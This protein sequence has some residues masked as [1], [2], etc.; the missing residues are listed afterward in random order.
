ML[1]ES[2]RK[3]RAGWQASRVRTL[4]KYVRRTLVVF[5]ALVA[6]AVVSSL[7]LDLGPRV[8]ALA[9]REGSKQIER[10][11]HI[12]RLSIRLLTGTFILE[13][14]TIEGLTPEDRPFLKAKRIA[15]SMPWWTI[16]RRE[17]LIDSVDMSDWQMVVETFPGN[18]NN[19]P[20]FTRGGPTPPGQRRFT[21]TVQYAR[22]HRGE[23]TFED[24]AVPWSTVARNLDIDVAKLGEY[25]GHARFSG[26]TVKVM[27]YEPMSA[28]MR[29]SFVIRNNK[30]VFDRVN[31]DTDGAESFVTG[32]VDLPRWPE[33]RYQVRSRIHFPRMRELFFARQTFRLQGDGEFVGTF[34]LFKGGRRLT[35]SF[36]SESAGVNDFRFGALEGELDW[37]PNRFDVTRATARFHDGDVAFTY[38]MAPIGVRREAGDGAVRHDL[39]RRPA[40]RVHGLSRIAGRT[41]R[42]AGI[43]SYAARM[44]AGAVLGKTR[45]RPH[46]GCAAAGRKR[47]P[48]TASGPVVGRK[49]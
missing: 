5:V 4:W 34:H 22:A 29:A 44:A 8:R 47:A 26:G 23:L 6:A 14:F 30:I 11:M 31:L 3:V 48:A 18:R 25:R 41:A 16:V 32:E 49:R 10:P 40:G 21:T 36:S 24:H 27:N 20:R 39:H 12:G 2:W 38:S 17:V 19:F 45:R 13:D 28:A 15:V 1:N 33:Q 43:G 9:E 35:G 7:T 42:R 46:D 37:R